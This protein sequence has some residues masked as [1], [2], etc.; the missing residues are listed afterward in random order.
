MSTEEQRIVALEQGL[1]GVQ[2]EFLVHLSESNRQIASLNKVMT[3]Q[4]LSGRDID[5]NLTMLLDMAIDQDK[6]I[7]AMQI[8][9][10]T[11]KEQVADIQQNMN[12]L[13]E[14][15]GKHLEPQDK[16]LE[17]LD[18]KLEQVLKMLSWLT[19]RSE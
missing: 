8:E 9:L 1:R 2:N 12:D 14:T 3:T 15:Q 19:N 5:H 4:E 18:S 7:R 10:G 17:A 11:V 13:F 6:H 16:R